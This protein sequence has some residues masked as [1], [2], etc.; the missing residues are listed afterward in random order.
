MGKCQ[1]TGDCAQTMRILADS[2]RIGIIR[3]LL[4]G[5]ECVSNIA[6]TLGLPNTRISHHVAILRNFGIVEAH[7]EGRFIRYRIADWLTKDVDS[8]SELSLGCC[9]IRFLPI[10]VDGCRVPPAKNRGH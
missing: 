2:T 10:C 1:T 8:P 7:R 6:E 4:S 3:I 9:V 5:P